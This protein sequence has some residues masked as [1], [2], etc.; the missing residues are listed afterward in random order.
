MSLE[1]RKEVSHK[2][3]Q[4]VE[5]ENVFKEPLVDID[6]GDAKNRLQPWSMHITEDLYAY[7]RNVEGSGCVSPNYMAHQ[8]DINV[9]MRAI[10]VDWLIEM[11]H[12]STA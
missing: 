7:Y 2:I 12:T 10:L 9:K 6:I 8:S 3:D 5:M 4:T 11:L 1:K